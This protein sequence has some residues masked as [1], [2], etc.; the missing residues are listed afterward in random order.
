MPAKKEGR[1]FLLARAARAPSCAFKF[2]RTRYFRE[3]HNAVPDQ[4]VP[5]MR[6]QLKHFEQHSR[7]AAQQLG[8]AVKFDWVCPDWFAKR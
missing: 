5:P 6:V 1:V 2:V 8:L 7:P 4:I 3:V